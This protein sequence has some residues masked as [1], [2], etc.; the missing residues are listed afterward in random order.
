MWPVMIYRN[1]TDCANLY[2]LPVVKKWMM[3]EKG[4]DYI[5]DQSSDQ[6]NDP[7][8]CLAPVLADHRIQSVFEN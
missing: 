1:L 5:A 6:S 4:K 8:R 7:H 3:T 2:L